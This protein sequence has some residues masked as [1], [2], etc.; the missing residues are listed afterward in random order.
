MTSHTIARTSSNNDRDGTT[1]NY[2]YDE[3]IRASRPFTSDD[4]LSAALQRAKAMAGKNEARLRELLHPSFTWISHKGDWF[5]LESYLD[6][7]RRG[8]NTWHGQELRDPEVRVVDETAVL[9]CIVV[10][11][12]DI[13]SDQ[14]G[15]LHHANVPNV[16]PSG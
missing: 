3:T 13:G 8:S 2:R 5:D 16:D 9:R 14:P 1:G 6:S 15:D 10:D 4:V 11:S 7:N 12:V